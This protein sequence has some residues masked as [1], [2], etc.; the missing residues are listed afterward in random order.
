[1]GNL[2]CSNIREA[3]EGWLL[4]VLEFL[5]VLQYS[6]GTLSGVIQPYAGRLGRN[7]HELDRFMRSSIPAPGPV[8]ELREVPKAKN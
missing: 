2:V 1:V 3:I 6:C 5:D 7:R 8:R 4:A